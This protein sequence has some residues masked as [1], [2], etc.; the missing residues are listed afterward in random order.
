MYFS[1]IASVF[2]AIGANAAALAPGSVELVPRAE[3][4]KGTHE[5][6]QGAPFRCCIYGYTYEQCCMR[7]DE[8]SDLFRSCTQF[9]ADGANE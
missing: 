7:D 4:P 8:P 9:V 2:L 6:G 5:L 3:C 1:V